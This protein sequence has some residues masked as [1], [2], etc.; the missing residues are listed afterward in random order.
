[1][2]TESVVRILR[3]FKEEG[4]LDLKGKTIEI[5]DVDRLQRISDLG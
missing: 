2:A 4:L 1:M 5:K 3:D